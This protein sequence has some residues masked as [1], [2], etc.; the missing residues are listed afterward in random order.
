MILLS[1]L[2]ASETSV[3]IHKRFLSYWAKR[4]IFKIKNSNRDIS[5]SRTQYDN[6]NSV[7]ASKSQDLRGNL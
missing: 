7:I 1:S 5:R 6:E 3:A 4:S 2:R